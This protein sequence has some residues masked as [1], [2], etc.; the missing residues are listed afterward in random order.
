MTSA[1]CHFPMKFNQAFIS[2]PH[3]SNLRLLELIL[4]VMP[5]IY[6]SYSLVEGEN[7]LP[8]WL[9]TI[10]MYQS[11]FYYPAT[12]HQKTAEHFDLWGKWGPN[13]LPQ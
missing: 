1:I 12:N 4:G 10:F 3:K 9:Q 6:Y 2:A 7:C 11:R 13:P 5:Q 8:F